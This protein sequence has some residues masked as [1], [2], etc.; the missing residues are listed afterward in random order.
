M[1]WYLRACVMSLLLA[2]AVMTLDV[3]H[4][5][6]AQEDRN[7]A[8]SSAG[9]KQSHGGTNRSVNVMGFAFGTPITLETDAV[10]DDRGRLLVKWLS[11]SAVSFAA[12]CL[13]LVLGCGA[14]T[15]VS[16]KHFR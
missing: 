10:S 1:K 6:N 12:C 3:M 14:P 15:P 16:T 5:R 4:A 13:V 9:S 7:A 11:L 2:G 8:Y